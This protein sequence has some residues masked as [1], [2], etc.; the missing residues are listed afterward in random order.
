MKQSLC[1][2]IKESTNRLRMACSIDP[3]ETLLALALEQLSSTCKQHP[4][5]QGAGRENTSR[6]IA[7]SWARGHL[8]LESCSGLDCSH[9]AEREPGLTACNRSRAHV[10]RQND[11]TNRTSLYGASS[12]DDIPHSSDLRVFD[13]H[14]T[15]AA[16]LRS[17][18]LVAQV[19]EHG[20]SQHLGLDWLA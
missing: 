3:Q 16:S 12:C 9:A 7:T 18:I 14:Q 4:C 6:Y 5:R 17:E 15:S 20:L 11:T 2:H 8:Q 19:R 1:I 13:D 10:Q